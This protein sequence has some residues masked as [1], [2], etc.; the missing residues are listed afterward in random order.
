M[1]QELSLLNGIEENS[2]DIS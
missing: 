1:R 2:R